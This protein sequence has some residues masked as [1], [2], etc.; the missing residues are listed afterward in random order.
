MIGTGGVGKTSLANAL[1]EAKSNQAHVL[2][3]SGTFNLHV[4]ITSHYTSS[5][6][7]SMIPEGYWMKEMK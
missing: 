1:L 5:Q 3:W 4:H 6:Y 7:N 2:A